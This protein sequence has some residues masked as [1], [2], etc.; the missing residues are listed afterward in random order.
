MW[1][2]VRLVSRKCL[3]SDKA[4][5]TLANTAW[6]PGFEHVSCYEVTQALPPCAAR[7]TCKVLVLAFLLSAWHVE[8]NSSASRERVLSSCALSSNP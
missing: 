5:R 7:V 6:T 1:S 8:A 3:T 4:Y 2:C